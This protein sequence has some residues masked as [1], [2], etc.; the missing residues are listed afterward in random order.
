MSKRKAFIIGTSLGLLFILAAG[1]G[2]LTFLNRG[3]DDKESFIMAICFILAL[4]AYGIIFYKSKE[5]A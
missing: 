3:G 2:G 5:Q 1:S 4:I